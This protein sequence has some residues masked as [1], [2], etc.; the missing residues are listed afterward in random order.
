MAKMV[1]STSPHITSKST[2]QR[3]MLDVI[4]ALLPALIATV[5]IFGVYP[6]WY[7]L[8]FLDLWFDACH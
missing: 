7:S 2:T 8:S 1:V 3:I 4:I 6:T 5:V